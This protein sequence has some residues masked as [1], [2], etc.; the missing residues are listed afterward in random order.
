MPLA[1]LLAG[2]MAAGATP[3]PLE[4]ARDHQDR[5]ALQKLAADAG[6]AAGRAPNDAAAQLNAALAYSYLAEVAIEQHDRKPGRQAAEQGIAFA[7]KATQLKQDS[8]EGY[9]IL[10]TLYGQAITD[11]LSGLSYGAKAKD[12][13]GKAV[14]LAPNSAEVWTAHGVGNYY[15]PVQLGGGPE[16]AVG[17]FHKAISLDA[18]N[19]EAWL[20]LGVALRKEGKNGEARDAFAKSQALNPGRVWVKQQLDKTPAK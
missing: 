12:A 3:S 16:L 11:V 6:A 15:L 4:M 8:A 14:K 20:W 2:F 18:K 10:G 5:G 1:L 7:L 19:A 17:D 9:R 13:L